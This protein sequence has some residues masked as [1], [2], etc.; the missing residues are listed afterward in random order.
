MLFQ[1]YP[2]ADALA[3]DALTRQ[4]RA[5]K[6]SGR[7]GVLA[8]EIMNSVVTGVAFA[9]TAIAPEFHIAISGKAERRGVLMDLPF[10][11]WPAPPPGRAAI[12][13]FTPRQPCDPSGRPWVPTW[14]R[15][16][17]RLTRTFVERVRRRRELRRLRAAW[18]MVDDRT[19]EDIGLSR[20]AVAQLGGERLWR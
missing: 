9:A 11:P 8:S 19:F 4:A 12:G 15:F 10:G 16:L 17:A 7:I 20:C 14:V 2:A 1:N 6:I 13:V 18:D 3:V 5:A